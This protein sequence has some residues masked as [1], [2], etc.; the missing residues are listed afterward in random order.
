MDRTRLVINE[1]IYHWHQPCITSAYAP[2][3]TVNKTNET[4]KQTCV[5]KYIPVFIHTLSVEINSNLKKQ[6]I[7]THSAQEIFI[8]TALIINIECTT[9]TLTFDIKPIGMT[10][11]SKHTE[12]K[13]M[14]VKKSKFVW[15][16]EKS[17]DHYLKNCTR[18]WVTCNITLP[19]S[20]LHHLTSFPH[21]NHSVESISI[22]W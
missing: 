5:K 15:E 11:Y 22:V 13:L 20:S 3:L 8:K 19:F 10:L 1:S 12:K 18:S 2:N 16:S 6:I 17:H 9:E 21:F 7:K 14:F 4:F